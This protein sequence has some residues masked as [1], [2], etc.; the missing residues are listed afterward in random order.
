MKGDKVLY[1][2]NFTLDCMAFFWFV[3]PTW[4]ILAA[5]GNLFF[6]SI[7]A[8]VNPLDFVL[9]CNAVSERK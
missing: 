1:Y 9:I 4:I 6:F 8:S 7:F 2:S 5:V 3:S